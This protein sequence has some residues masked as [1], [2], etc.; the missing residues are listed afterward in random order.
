MPQHA[1]EPD[2]RRPRRRDTDDVKIRNEKDLETYEGIFAE[3]RVL[4]EDRR[5]IP[6]PADRHRHGA[7]HADPDLGLRD[8]EREVYDQFGRRRVVPVRTYMERK[9]FILRPKFIFIDGRTGATLYSETFREEILYNA[10]QNTPALSSYFELMD[11]LIPS[12][13]ST[14]S[15]QKIRG[16]RVLLE[17]ARPAS[18]AVGTSLRRLTVTPQEPVIASILRAIVRESVPSLRRSLTSLC[19]RATH[20]PCTVDGGGVE[21]VRNHSKRRPPG[22]GDA[23]RRRSPSTASTASRARK[24]ASTR[25][26]LLEKDGG[27]VLAGAPFVANARVVGVVDG[28]TR[29]PKIRVFKKKR[30]KGM[31]R[32]KGI[33]APTRACASR[34]FWSSH[35]SQKRTRQLTQRPRQ[36]LAAARRQAHDGNIVTGG[37]ILVRQRGR[38]FRPGLNVGLGKDDTLFAK[39]DGTGEVRG[40]RR[41]RP[42]HQHPPARAGRRPRNR[43][44]RP[45]T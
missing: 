19:R 8:A 24:S 22:E 31:R 26:S 1:P 9:G 28:E 35:G 37:S 17:V 3:H 36:Q 16:T 11:Q 40:S 42:R 25:C 20:R 38:R 27:E 7:V 44:R 21:R 6:E 18:S 5:G 10:Q 13:L 33:A 15:T 14:L 29:G 32:T 39:V 41:A 43:S 30:R 2:C 12:F 4:E 34:T 23:G 45:T